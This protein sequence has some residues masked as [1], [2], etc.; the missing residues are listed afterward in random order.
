M[1]QDKIKT[2]VRSQSKDKHGRFTIAGIY[3]LA[4]DG[5]KKDLANLRRRRSISLDE[6]RRIIMLY[7]YYGIN[8]A[9][10]GYSFRFYRYFGEVR[11]VKTLTKL[12]N[13]VSSQIRIVDGVRVSIKTDLS[14]SI[15]R[16]G[17]YWHF[18]NW[19]C[20]KKWR[21]HSFKLNR[22]WI[23]KMMDRVETGFDYLDYT[24]IGMTDGYVRK[25]R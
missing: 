22:R 8:D 7:F 14:Q 23:K 25:I 20:P 10:N 24:Y 13:P 18:F 3:E 17:G 19:D 12:Y 2:S 6:F 11:V 1:M 15:K 4:K 16:H 21:T 9:I 5:I